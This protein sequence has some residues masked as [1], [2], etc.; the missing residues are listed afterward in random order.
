VAI[1]VA[2]GDLMAVTLW[3]VASF[4]FTMLAY[5]AAASRFLPFRALLPG[6]SGQAARDQWRFSANVSGYMVMATVFMQSDK[7]V[8]SKLLPL[9][10]FGYY[11]VV[12]TA[13]WKVASLATAVSAAAFPALVESHGA[14]QRERMNAQYR[15]LQDLVCHA[16]IIPIAALAFGALPAFT[17]LFSAG[18]A[19]SMVVPVLLLSLAYYMHITLS[20][21]LAVAG[22]TGRPELIMK[23]NV[24]ALFTF[25]PALIGLVVLFGLTGAGLAW[26]GYY[27][28]AYGYL[29]PRVCRRCL[30]VS[31]LV[32]YSQ[33]GRIILKVSVSYG[34]G[35][36]LC[37]ILHRSGE[38]AWTAAFILSTGVFVGLSLLSAGRRDS[39]KVGWAR[40]RRVELRR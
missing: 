16:S 27:G 12:W 22:A 6:W 1:L 14:G 3:M 39:V 34:I 19:A 20:M 18:I 4:T 36:S 28:L 24:I 10:A 21:P 15:K 23:L 37:F 17:Y 31:T 9:S 13:V 8:V 35:W 38:L 7:L 33:I 30:G 11:S 32:W 5:V 26:L 29:V 2:G 25:L 40:M